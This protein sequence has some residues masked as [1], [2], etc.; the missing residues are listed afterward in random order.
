MP[1]S[2]I[3]II[4]RELIAARGASGNLVS[5]VSMVY[6]CLLNA[7]R[8]LMLTLLE[9][10]AQL[11]GNKLNYLHFRQNRDRTLLLRSMKRGCFLLHS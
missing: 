6:A 9:F 11:R 5:T 2:R 4:C 10:I 7:Y 3:G 8:N 1:R